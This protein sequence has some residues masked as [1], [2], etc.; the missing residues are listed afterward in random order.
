MPTTIVNLIEQVIVQ[1]KL[2]VEKI[3]KIG[4]TDFHD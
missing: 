4:H 3:V 1:L 2:H